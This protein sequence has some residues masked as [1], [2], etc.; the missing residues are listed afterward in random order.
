MSVRGLQPS[1][2]DEWYTPPEIF[3]ALG[4]TFDLDP[5]ASIQVATRFVPAKYHYTKEDDGLAKSWHGLVFMNPP[6]GGRH[7]HVPWLHRFLSHQNG[8]AIVRAYTSADWFHELAVRA[9][10]MLFPKG[11]TRFIRPDGTR[12]ECP[13]TG[14]VL[15]AMGSMAK[16]HLRGSRLGMFVSHWDAA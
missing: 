6:F 3:E 12:G 8:I 5:C 4:L 16:Q 15:L 1:E 7:A 9:D 2:S 10:A 11:K 13:S 14:V